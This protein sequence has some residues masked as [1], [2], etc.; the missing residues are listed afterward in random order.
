MPRATP[1]ATEILLAVEVVVVADRVVDEQD[2][3]VPVEPLAAAPPPTCSPGLFGSFAG[4]PRDGLVVGEH[5]REAGDGA[6]PVASQAFGQVPLGDAE[7]LEE[8]VEVPD[9]ADVELAGRAPSPSSS[10]RRSLSAVKL[11][12][13]KSKTRGS[14]RAGRRARSSAVA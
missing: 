10:T 9:Q 7:Q 4:P 6:E 12:G 11:A 1:S 2:R 5:G 14:H 3:E 8:L 13:V